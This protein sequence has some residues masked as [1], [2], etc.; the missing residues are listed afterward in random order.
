MG[1]SNGMFDS[2]NL[3]VAAPYFISG[4]SGTIAAL[5]AG[6]AVARLVHFGMI[7]PRAPGVLQA[8]PIRISQIR[9]KYLPV[10]ALTTGI[11]FEIQKGT[12]TTQH[13][14]GGAVH[15]PK[16][17]KTTGYPAILA[18]ETNLFVSTTGAI[19]GGS[20]WAPVDADADAPFDLV[21]GG[22]GF[23]GCDSVWT[24]SDTMPQTL[25]AGEALEVRSN[26]A[27]TGTGIF[28]V[29]IDFYR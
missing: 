21:T 19:S 17:R 28:F 11:G 3:S 26:V 15:V 5:A 8:T 9:M 13:S 12:A 22:T 16:R 20:A 14:V 10:T 27:L 7:D 1:G 23:Q 29:A 4:R 25:E 6:D 2:G 18:A 24:P